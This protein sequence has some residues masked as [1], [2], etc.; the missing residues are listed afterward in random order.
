MNFYLKDRFGVKFK[1]YKG[2]MMKKRAVKS[3]AL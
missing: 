3:S 2:E 1:T